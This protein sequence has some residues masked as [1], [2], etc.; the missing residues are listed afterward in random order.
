[1][2]PIQR[3]HVPTSTNHVSSMPSLPQR[4]P[5][6][7]KHTL[8]A[9]TIARV[10]DMGTRGTSYTTHT[11]LLLFMQTIRSLS[12]GAAQCGRYNVPKSPHTPDMS[13]FL[14]LSLR[15]MNLN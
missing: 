5:R 1:M 4:L 8:A 11:R 13:A 14:S 9:E 3:P 12:H 7:H 6:W 10:G 2:E 15:P